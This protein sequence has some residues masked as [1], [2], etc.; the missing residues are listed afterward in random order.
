MR[1]LKR[2]VKIGGTDGLNTEIISGITSKDRVV[3]KGAMMIKL[4][5]ATGTLDANSGHNH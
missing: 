2:E 1:Q 3:S 4:A 5:Q